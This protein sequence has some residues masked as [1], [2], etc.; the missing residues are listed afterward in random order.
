MTVGITITQGEGLEGIVITD[1]KV[2]SMLD[3]ESNSVNKI[4]L[5]QPNNDR[6]FHGVL[7]GAGSGHVVAQAIKS[8]ANID[9]NNIEAFAEE[10]G[11]NWRENYHAVE[12]K[13][14]ENL[15]KEAY[16]RASLYLTGDIENATESEKQRYNENLYRRLNEVESHLGELIKGFNGNLLLVG[17]DKNKNKIRKFGIQR[18]GEEELFAEHIEI[19]SGADG[20][21]FY[22]SEKL[23]GIPLDAKLGTEELLFYAV[24]AYNASNMNQGVGGRPRIVNV[25]KESNKEFTPEQT[26]M[27]VNLS[28]AYLSEI[29]Q[30]ELTRTDTVEFI[31]RIMEND[32]DAYKEI[33]KILDPQH[34][35]LS[36]MIIDPSSWRESANHEYYKS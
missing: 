13:I 20:A 3:R 35:L 34:D 9:S 18:L 14:R 10:I 19:G 21:N 26:R 32:K 7:Y 1:S 28:S 36:R 4:G 17:Y 23:Q 31:K 5:I 11:K 27:L 25:N 8:I 33:T 12:R 22:F 16:N 24:N 29:K 15:K 2:T 6:N 30:E